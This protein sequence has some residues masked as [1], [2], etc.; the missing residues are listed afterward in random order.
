MLADIFDPTKPEP[1]VSPHED[2]FKPVCTTVHI[3]NLHRDLEGDSCLHRLKVIS[4]SSPRRPDAGDRGTPSPPCQLL[5]VVCPRRDSNPQF[6]AR[7]I[8]FKDRCVYQFRHTGMWY[9]QGERLAFHAGRDFLRVS[10]CFVSSLRIRK[11]LSL[12][13]GG[14]HRL[15][16]SSRLILRIGVNE[17]DS[18]RECRFQLILA[19]AR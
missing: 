13:V 3:H 5:Y 10:P 8:G 6:P 16:I 11:A 17:V 1:T 2:A 12:A 4:F 18:G 19:L 7:D 9:L 15:V 14:M